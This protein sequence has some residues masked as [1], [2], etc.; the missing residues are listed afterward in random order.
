MYSKPSD[1]WAF[2]V[3]IWELFTLID[4]ERDEGDEDISNIP[5]H[6]RNSKKEVIFI[7]FN[8]SNR[9]FLYAATHNTF[10]K[11]S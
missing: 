10:A 7:N 4:K 6:N 2:A 5:Y 1:I 3:L 11:E 8:C 9:I